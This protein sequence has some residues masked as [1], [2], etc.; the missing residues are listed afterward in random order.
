M[1]KEKGKLKHKIILAYS[2]SSVKQKD[3]VKFLREL[4]G[5]KEKKRKV[6]YHKG[7]LDKIKGEKIASNV[8]MAEFKDLI[9]LSELFNRYNI[10]P[11]IIEVWTK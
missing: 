5:Y 1:E 6:Y 8:I 9:T 11:R 3:K 2:L 4:F 7:L 10:K